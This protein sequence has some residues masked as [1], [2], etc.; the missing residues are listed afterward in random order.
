MKQK[1]STLWQVG[2]SSSLAV[3]LLSVSAQGEEA[4]KK[5]T[6]LQTAASTE[7]A[8]AS[9]PSQPT[10]SHEHEGNTMKKT[11]TSQSS[12]ASPS[13]SQTERV[14]QAIALAQQAR[15]HAYVPYSKFRMGASV[16]TD[17]GVLLP[18]TVVENVSLGLAMC[19][20]RVALFSAVAQQA[21]RPDLLTLVAPRTDGQLTFPCG[22]CL[23]VAMELGGPDLQV[24]A[25]DPH[26][27][28]EEARVRD[29]ATRLP[30]KGHK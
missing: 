13:S 27:H 3:L 7:S 5:E 30:Y 2:A 24:V 14:A 26:G 6:S 22:A 9:D 15:E 10:S 11:K 21:G 18:G 25:C 8:S 29:L 12:A 16:G 1:K 28:C 20:E 17:K 19:A 23:Q 4:G